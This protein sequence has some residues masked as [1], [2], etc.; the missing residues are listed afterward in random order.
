MSR[1]SPNSA[2][3]RPKKHRWTR[4]N[5]I[6]LALLCRKYRFS[7]QKHQILAIWNEVYKQQLLEERFP[8]GK[9]SLGTMESQRAEMLRRHGTGSDTWNEVSRHSLQAATRMFSAE[10][11]LINAAER[12]PIAGQLEVVAITCADEDEWSDS[13]SE[14]SN[15]AVEDRQQPNE[16]LEDEVE[17]QHLSPASYQ[18]SVEGNNLGQI[19]RRPLSRPLLRTQHS[20]GQWTVKCPTL[21]FRGFQRNHGL[22]ARRYASATGPVP[23]PPAFDS[24]RFRKEVAGHLMGKIPY[25]S[26]FLSFGQS[27]SNALKWVH[28]GR[29]LAISLVEDIIADA[30]HRYGEMKHPY[31]YLAHHVVHEHRLFGLPGKYKGRGEVGTRSLSTSMLADNLQF[32]CWGSVECEPILVLEH[33]QAIDLETTMKSI[34]QIDDESGE[35]LGRVSST[36]DLLSTFDC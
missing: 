13:S 1:H 20:F 5:R 19:L 25:A 8:E 28:G 16:H 6:V 29:D 15:D 14:P 31:P 2:S 36:S 10:N 32:L 9:L 3:R 22:R 7:T 34:E 17:I 23:P 27:V 21:L 4:E 12:K 11:A 24:S 18:E 26:P 30:N 33:G 35:M